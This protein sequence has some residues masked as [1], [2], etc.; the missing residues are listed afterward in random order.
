MPTVKPSSFHLRFDH[1]GLGLQG[2]LASSHSLPFGCVRGVTEVFRFDIT[3]LPF[4]FPPS[5]CD[6]CRNQ[7]TI[8]IKDHCRP[9]A[10]L[11]LELVA[12]FLSPT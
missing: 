9:G 11:F 5:R 2:G 10:F 4:C 1:R 8:V 12:V 7:R 6:N 3:F